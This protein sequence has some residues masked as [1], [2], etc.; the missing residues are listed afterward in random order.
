[1]STLVLRKKISENDTNWIE[2]L[3]RRLFASIPSSLLKLYPASDVDGQP[4]VDNQDFD[5]LLSLHGVHEQ[6]ISAMDRSA[7]L[8]QIMV[9]Y[10]SRGFIVSIMQDFDHLITRP[11]QL[12]VGFGVPGEKAVATLRGESIVQMGAGTGYFA[13]ILRKG[14]ANVLAYDLHPP[15]SG[16]NPFFD[17]SYIDDIQSGSCKDVFQNHPSLALSY[18]LLLVWPNDPDPVDNVQFCGGGGCD[19]SE[20][21]WDVDCLSCYIEAGG[22]KVIYVGEREANLSKLNPETSLDCGLSSTRRFQGILEEHFSLY[23]TVDIPKWWL[24][25]DDLT[26][27]SKKS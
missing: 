12:G 5:A 19:G 9:P 14:G 7:L 25:E 1:M 4:L 17:V 18:S 8:N 27:W 20:S 6:E 16:E 10:R 22:S 26:I 2:E 24:N 11:I 13:A 21:V 15:G 3:H 23:K